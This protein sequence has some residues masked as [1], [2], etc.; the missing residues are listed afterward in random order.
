MDYKKIYHNIIKKSI[1]ENRN[2]SNGVYY[3]KH[4]ILPKSLG[5]NNSKNN[6]VLLTAREHFICHWL[7]WKFTEGKNKIK[8]GHAF[9]LMRYHD[10]NNRYYN[11][12]GY[13]VARKAHAFSASLLHKGKKLSE[14]ELKRMSDN[15]PNAKEI[16]INGISYSSRKEAIISLKTTKRRLYKF[17]NNEITF[18]QMIYDGRYSHNENTKLK[19]GKWSKGKTYEELY[20]TKKA[21]DLKEKRRLSKKNKRLSQET[22]TKIS[23]SHLKRKTNV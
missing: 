1:L 8:M 14:K 22:K 10:S 6:I 20:G 4:H 17:L 18:E 11:S 7:L 15:N 9:G 19:I 23:Q 16:T 5:G 2:I 12:V 3:E 21:L 13:E